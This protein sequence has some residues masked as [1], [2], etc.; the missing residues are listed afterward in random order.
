MTVGPPFYNNVAI[1]VVLLL[2]LLTAVGPLLAW[3]KTS[4][5]SLKRNFFWPALGAVLVGAL[6]VAFGVRPWKDISY[7]Y[8]LMA[9]MMA[10]HAVPLVTGE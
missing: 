7:L 6:M 3:R 2:L 4:F 5:E 1:P 10:S 8:A 9:A